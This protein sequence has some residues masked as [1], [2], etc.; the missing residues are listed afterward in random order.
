MG[1]W[2]PITIRA[3]LTG[4]DLWA[5]LRILTFSWNIASLA[6]DKSFIFVRTA[7]YIFPL[8]RLR[9]AW[10]TMFTIMLY[11]VDGFFS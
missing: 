10:F 7:I 8:I 2:T 11:T 9:E 3:F 1:I 6:A 4:I 5:F